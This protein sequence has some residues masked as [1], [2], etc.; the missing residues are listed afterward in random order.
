[1]VFTPGGMVR[2]C[3][4]WPEAVSALA[5]HDRIVARA[6]ETGIGAGPDRALEAHGPG[7]R[8]AGRHRARGAE[9]GDYR[10]DVGEIGAPAEIVRADSVGVCLPVSV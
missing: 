4:V 1:M 9:I 6:E 5:T 3:D 7:D 10:A 8:D 2:A